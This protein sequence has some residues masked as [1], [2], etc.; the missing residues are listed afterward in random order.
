MA[1]LAA[2]LLAAPITIL[3][4]A[5]DQKVRGL[6]YNEDESEFF[7]HCGRIP[8]GKS[9]EML[10]QYIDVLANAKITALFCTVNARRVNYRSGVWASYWDGYDPNGG[11]DQPIFKTIPTE[12]ERKGWHQFVRNVWQVHQDGVDY[13]AHVISRCRVHG[14]IPWISIRMNDCHF[15]SNLDHPFH[16]SI[17]RKKELFR[18][19]DSGYFATALDYAHGE[20]RDHFRRLIVE[21]LE[22]YDVDGI[23]LDFLREPYL[24][25]VGEEGAGS[26]ILTQWLSEIRRL[27]EKAAALRGHPVRLGVRIPSEPDVALGLGLD[28]PTW[29][30]R[31][32]I[33]LAVVGP[34]WQTLHFDLPIQEWRR[35]LGDH[36]SLAGSLEVNYQPDPSK[37]SRVV[38]PEEAAGA[39]LSIWSAGADATYLFN[40]YQNSHPHW[41]P[42][43]YQKMVSSCGSPERLKQ[44]PRVYAVTQRDIAVPGKARRVSLPATGSDLSFHLPLGPRPPIDWKAEVTIRCTDLTTSKNL[45]KVTVNGTACTPV[46]DQI[47]KDDDLRFALPSSAILGD[48]TD[49]IKI[50]HAEHREMKI[51]L[52]EVRL[53]PTK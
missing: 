21:V 33:D 22:R 16:A 52:L 15:N 5:S 40:Y 53:T 7:S 34:R 23:E 46:K 20:V 14:I 8:A 3:G 31:G 43:V 39:A 10:D 41:S 4:Q 9:G 1:A 19:K 6:L 24:F 48:G 29:V 36:V 38:K 27:T 2:V 17:F 51:T 44:L 25:S 37:P 32:L 35:L 30:K 42:E 28:V 12:S 49:T 18:K 50:F 26:I 13:P 45:F 47:S 11:D